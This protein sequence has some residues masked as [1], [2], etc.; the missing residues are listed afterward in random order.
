MKR[1]E[2]QSQVLNISRNISR[3]T[4]QQDDTKDVK[5]SAL[6]KGSINCQSVNSHNISDKLKYMQIN[7]IMDDEMVADILSPQPRKMKSKT[8]FVTL[9]Q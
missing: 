6:R 4:S 7:D 2:A 8:T 9:A 3:K 5:F 1:L